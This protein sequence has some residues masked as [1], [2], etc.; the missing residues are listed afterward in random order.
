MKRWFW[1]FAVVFAVIV[2]G[3]RQGEKHD[4]KENERIAQLVAEL[5]KQ[6]ALVDA[7]YFNS[8]AIKILREVTELIEAGKLSEAIELSDRYLASGNEVLL[9]ANLGAKTKRLTDLLSDIPERDSSRR[10]QVF[11]ELAKLHP[12]HAQFK[13]RAAYYRA[14][15]QKEK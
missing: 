7:N 12:D 14:M 2:I 15:T 11:G 10:A 13:Q 5:E 6:D 1:A 9:K 8:N 4:Q 3:S